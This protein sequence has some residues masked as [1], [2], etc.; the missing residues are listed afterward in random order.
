[1]NCEPKRLASF[2]VLSQSKVGTSLSIQIVPVV[3]VSFFFFRKNR[4]L[5]TEIY[6]IFGWSYA[7][8]LQELSINLY[9]PFTAGSLE[10]ILNL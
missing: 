3:F 5:I 10:I 9:A 8:Y 6:H 7:T 2:V 1:M 4:T